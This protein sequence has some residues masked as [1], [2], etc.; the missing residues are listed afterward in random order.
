MSYTPKLRAVFPG[1]IFP[2]EKVGFYG[3]FRADNTDDLREIRLGGYNCEIDDDTPIP[4][5]YT[6]IFSCLIGTDVD[7]GNYK[8]SLK[9]KLRGNAQNYKSSQTVFSDY[10]DYYHVSVH[11]QATKSGG[12][13]VY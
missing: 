10:S 4:W 11:P 1:S 8:A 13:T 7:S 6:G 2:G 5:S 3:W 12:L 9:N